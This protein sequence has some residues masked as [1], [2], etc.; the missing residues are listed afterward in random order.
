M[1]C[2]RKLDQIVCLIYEDVTVVWAFTEHLLCRTWAS[3][4]SSHR[5]CSVRKA[6]LRNFANFTG[7]HL[8]KSLFFNKVSGLRPATLLKKETLAHVSSCEFC[9][10]F[11]NTFFTIKYS[12]FGPAFFR[13]ATN[14]PKIL[15]VL[16]KAIRVWIS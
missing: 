2:V 14:P 13:W 6:I 11:R 3:D 1:Y 9:E 7:K 16:Q 15:V 10:I 8:C 12:H 5:K 4:R